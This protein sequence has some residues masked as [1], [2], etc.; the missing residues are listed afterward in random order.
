MSLPDVDHCVASERSF[1]FS[2]FPNLQEVYFGFPVNS[3]VGGLLWIPTALST[4]RR[5]TSPRL[6]SL[7]LDCVGSSTDQSIRTLIEDMGNDLRRIANEFTRIDREFKGTV[8]LT[9]VRDPGFEMVLDALNV[10]TRFSC[11]G[12][13]LAIL[14]IHRRLIIYFPQILQQHEPRLR[15]SNW[16]TLR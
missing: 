16:G 11:S 4:L 8:N 5:A 12:Y 6:S 9:V 2:K 13:H 3:M 14:S 1:D 10:S 15:N 7:R